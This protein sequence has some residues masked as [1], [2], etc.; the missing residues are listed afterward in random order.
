MRPPWKPIGAY[1]TAR[2]MVIA[3]MGPSS[4][5][6]PIKAASM[7]VL[8]M[9]TWRSTFS[10]TTMASST[11]RPT[12]S[13]MA[14]IVSRFRLNPNAYITTAAPMS[15]TGIAMSG[16]SAVR[17][18]AHE[19]EHR[20]AD[21]QD[22]LRQCLGDFF[23][24]VAHEHRAVPHEAHVHVRRQ[25]RADAFHLGLQAFRHVELVRADERPDAEVDA[26]RFA[27]LRDGGGFFGAELDAGNVAQADDARRCGLPR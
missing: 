23:Q 22:R 20:E 11:T 1:T 16:T 15:D 18:G 2:V 10:T 7:R 8:P 13:T 25:R 27:V 12:A 24:R 14:S 5:R 19:Q 3:M 26:F 4:S 9:R 17:I 6:A 21:D